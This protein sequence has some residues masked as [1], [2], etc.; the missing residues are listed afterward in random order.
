LLQEITGP[1]NATAPSVSADATVSGSSTPV[2][3]FDPGT[4]AALFAIQ[5]QNAKGAVAQSP[6]QLF[7][8]LDADGD[9]QISK[10][11][12]E[13]ALGNA[14]VDTSSADALFARL[15]R[16]GDGSVSQ[17]EL[18]A[19]HRGH[20]HHAHGDGG[21]KSAGDA[22]AQQQDGLSSLLSVSDA[23]GATTQSAT[24]GDGSTTTPISYADGTRVE[25]TTPAA[26]SGNGSSE[27]GNATSSNLIA[28]LIDL[29]S[30]L[31][32]PAPNS[33]ATIA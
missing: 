32:N 14:G 19:V 24:N 3:S 6:S 9:G 7:A 20:H 15:D 21:S 22:S 27:V 30:S 4:F 13:T 2:G 10:S 1:P 16:N 8:K 31:L 17:S 29:Q 5:G 28:Q 11:E 33:L 23:A 26:Q 12:F 25:M 18:P